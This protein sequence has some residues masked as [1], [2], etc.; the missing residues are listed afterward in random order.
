M[1]SFRPDC[2]YCRGVLRHSEKEHARAVRDFEGVL[3]RVRGQ[4]HARIIEP[5]DVDRVVDCVRLTRPRLEVKLTTPVIYDCGL[6]MR[7]G[8][9]WYTRA[10]EPHDRELVRLTPDVCRVPRPERSRK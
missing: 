1:I 10:V 9:Q 6:L 3:V 7:I 8:R 5:H 2:L 4:W